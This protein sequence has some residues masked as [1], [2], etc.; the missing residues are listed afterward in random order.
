M[1][2]SEVFGLCHWHVEL[3]LTEMEKEAGLGWGGE[4]QEFDQRHDKLVI[5]R[6]VLMSVP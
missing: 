1:D 4:D 5:V 3:S 2:Y 6:K